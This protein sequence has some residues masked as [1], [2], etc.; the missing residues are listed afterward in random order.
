MKYAD[1]IPIGLYTQAEFSCRQR[2]Y[3]VCRCK[4][5]VHSM[6]LKHNAMLVLNRA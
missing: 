3:P 4:P 6:I 1:L 5:E 2:A